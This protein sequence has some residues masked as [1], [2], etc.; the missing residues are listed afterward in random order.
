MTAEERTCS[1]AVTSVR[2]LRRLARSAGL[3][4]SVDAELARLE[5]AVEAAADAV[6]DQ[7]TEALRARSEHDQPRLF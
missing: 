3:P 5:A 4:P 1:E 7:T 2:G 6:R